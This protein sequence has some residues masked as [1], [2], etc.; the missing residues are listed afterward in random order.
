T[1]MVVLAFA[2]VGYHLWLVMAGLIPHL[3]SRPLHIIATL[4][5]VFL[6]TAQPATG[7]R[8]A[9]DVLLCAFGLA[10][11]L[12]VLVQHDML[13][14]QYGRLRGTTQFVVAWGLILLALEMARRQVKWA[15]PGTA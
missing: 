12:Y 14:N 4:P 5:F 8:R 3:I 7:W 6:F 10:A 15:M 13:D 2:S 9:V 11:C 1:L